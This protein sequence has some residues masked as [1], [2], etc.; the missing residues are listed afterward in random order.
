[1]SSFLSRLFGKSPAAPA[2]A[3]EPVTHK[4]CRIFPDPIKEA[5]GWRVA[6]RV[7]KDFPDGTR[8]HHLSRADTFTDRDQAVETSLDKARLAIDQLGDTLFT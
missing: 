6:A 2:A 7:E 4:S 3:A 1:M 5:G 8:T